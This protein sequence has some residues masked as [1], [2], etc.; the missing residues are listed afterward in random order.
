MSY[1]YTV[2][3][4]IYRPKKHLVLA[5]RGLGARALHL[6]LQNLLQGSRFRILVFR[7]SG[8]RF[9]V[10][11]FEFRASGFGFRV[12]GCELRVSGSGFLVSGFWFGFGFRASGF[13]FRVSGFGFRFSGFGFRVSGFGFRAPARCLTVYLVPP[14]WRDRIR[15]RSKVDGCVPAS[16][17]VNLEIVSQADGDKGLDTRPLRHFL[18]FGFRISGAGGY[19]LFFRISFSSWLQTSTCIFISQ[20]VFVKSFAKVNSRTNPSTYPS[21]LLKLTFA[22]RL[23]KHFL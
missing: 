18:V 19:S 5:C 9:R 15:F 2:L 7:I 6:L 3:I 12:L 4:R 22:K 13:G 11:G 21:F 8:F 23:Q 1:V 20:K 16:Q 10:S 14:I 17:R